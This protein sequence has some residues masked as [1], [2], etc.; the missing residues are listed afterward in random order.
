MEVHKNGLDACYEALNRLK[1]GKP[2]INAHTGIKF[3]KITPAI[4]SVEAGFDK[5]YLKKNRPHHLTLI[6]EIN[7][8]R[9]D[10]VVQ[11]KD[12][13]NHLKREQEKVKNLENQNHDL[14][15][16]I[17]K[18]VAQNLRLIERVRLLESICS[19]E[20]NVYP[21]KDS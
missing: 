8:F 4:V 15:N 1:E 7:A 18:V 11:A 10:H 5:G 20:N 17:Q 14:T 6:N 9:S 2:H 12:L 13:A 16:M 3:S 21:L 19:Q